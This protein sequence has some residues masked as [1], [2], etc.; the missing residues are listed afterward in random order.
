M[1]RRRDRREAQI[2]QEEYQA[3][4]GRGVK[5][6]IALLA[7]AFVVTLG[8]V[9]GTRMSSDAIA[10]LVGVIA[11]VAASIPCALLLLAVTRR[12][13]PEDQ[14]PYTTVSGP[15]PDHLGNRYGSSYEGCPS[16]PVIIVTGGN[17]VPQQ[18]A[19]WS[20]ASG[21]A[22]GTAFD[23]YTYGGA[24]PQGRREFR[25]MGYQEPETQAD[26]EA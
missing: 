14:E 26:W 9:V 13:Q 25:V 18:I 1:S 10:V 17:A 12:R 2:E 16:P 24:Q 11:G 19:P 8:V 21:L 4:H 5:Q 6:L 15:Y 20:T 23:P 3:S 7:V 22:G